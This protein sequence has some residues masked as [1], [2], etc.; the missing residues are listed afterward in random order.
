MTLELPDPKAARERIEQA[1]AAKNDTNLE[2]KKQNILKRIE[3]VNRLVLKKVN[4][5]VNC[6]KVTPEDLEVTEFNLY[7]ELK[8]WLEDAGYTV[9]Y[10]TKGVNVRQPYHVIRW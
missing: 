9:E 10:I 8:T 3:E 2:N 7:P 6:T 4:E 5:D 1:I